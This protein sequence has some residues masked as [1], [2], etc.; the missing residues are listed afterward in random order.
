MP[1]A[2]I[3]AMLLVGGG[4]LIL[5]ILGV[6]L[7]NTGAW[8]PTRDQPSAIP[9]RVDRPVP[10]V[11]LRDLQGNPVALGSLNGQVVLVN[12]WATWCP[13]CK[14]EMPVLQ[15]YYDTHRE[16]NFTLVAI[17][18]G[19]PIEQVQAFV[20]DYRLSFPVW[21]DPD[22]KILDALNEIHLPSSF[23]ID[24][25]GRMVL[26]WTGSISRETLEKYVTPLLEN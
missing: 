8:N 16:Q 22:E 10:A 15:D 21:A 18:I 3:A 24:A 20:K 25:R 2:Q 5:G 14:A 23:V 13:P 12:N 7:L 1:A 9:A 11:E 19:E 6:L 26:Y 4:L 17:N